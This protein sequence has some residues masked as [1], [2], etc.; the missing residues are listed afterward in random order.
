MRF[1]LSYIKDSDVTDHLVGDRVIDAVNDNLYGVQL[2]TRLEGIVVMPILMAEDAFRERVSYS[3]NLP[4]D[5]K[6]MIKLSKPSWQ[7]A[8]YDERLRLFSMMLVDAF[9]MC[10]KSVLSDADK[11]ALERVV[12]ETH[13]I[14]SEAGRVDRRQSGS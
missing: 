1:A 4:L 7:A 2:E 14:L 5:A 11:A 3:R 6:V 8:D 12:W 9:R 10:R 13:H